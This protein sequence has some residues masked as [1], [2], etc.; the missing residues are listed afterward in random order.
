MG[1]SGGFVR[2]LAAA[3]LAALAAG[4][5][6]MG[7]GAH[8]DWEANPKFPA[9]MKSFAE[10]VTATGRTPGLWL[11]PFMVS[12]KSRLAKDHPDWLLCDEHGAPVR[13]GIT[14]SGNPLCLDV[15]HPDVL[16]W[17]DQLIRKLR[18]WGY[19]YLKLDFLY[20][21]GLIGKRYRDIPREAAY[22]HALKVMREAAGDAY[23]LACGAP[24]LPS[25]GLCDGLR[26]GPD[27]SPYWLNKPLTVWLN[28]AVET[29]KSLAALVKLFSSAT[30][31]KAESP[32]KSVPRIVR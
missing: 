18:G 9:G 7:G 27:V 8:G 17:V 4:C 15:T 26:I 3:A 6:G 24:I 21:G 11:A 16:E 12:T 32:A 23:I 25:L 14:W 29:P 31:T 30:V 1:S 13:A 28:V 2:S 10:K 5:A 19:G 20:I 22:R